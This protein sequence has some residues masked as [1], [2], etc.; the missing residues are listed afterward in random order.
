MRLLRL[1]AGTGPIKGRRLLRAQRP[2][3]VL[4]PLTDGPASLVGSRT[5]IVSLLEEPHGRVASLWSR[6]LEL[7]QARRSALVLAPDRAA[8][9]AGVRRWGI[10]LA[11]VR[12]LPAGGEDLESWLERELGQDSLREGRSWHSA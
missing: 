2:D 3:V 4:A 11:R 12:F 8:A 1:P 6:L 5:T 7:W 10:D 9:I